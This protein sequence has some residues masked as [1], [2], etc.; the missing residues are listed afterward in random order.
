M[1]LRLGG[2]LASGRTDAKQAVAHDIMLGFITL[3]AQQVPA[4]ETDWVGE[5]REV[6]SQWI[7]D[8]LRPGTHLAMAVLGGWL[9]LVVGLLVLLICIRYRVGEKYLIVSIF[10][11][12][13]RWVRLT[14]IRHVGTARVRFAE[15]WHNQ[16]LVKPQTVLVIRKRRGLIKNL[17]ITPLHRH[18][19]MA[20][21]ERARDALI[22]SEGAPDDFGGPHR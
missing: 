11:I 13:V 14:N 10:G 17:V 21:I 4:R 1:R 18:A 2:T 7:A 3:L 12:P 20:E 22:T 9:L 19:F 5:W 6:W 8:P 15:Q 16:I